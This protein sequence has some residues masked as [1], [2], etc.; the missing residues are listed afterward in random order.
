MKTFK[1][2]R[3]VDLSGVSGIG[4]VAEGVEFH[5]GKVVLSWLGKFHTIEIVPNIK[6]VLLIHGHQG[7]TEVVWNE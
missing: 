4:R 7:T 3:T 6:T 2:V 1:L 5:D